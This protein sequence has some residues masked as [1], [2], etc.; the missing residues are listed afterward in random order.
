M[1]LGILLC[2]SPPAQS[3]QATFGQLISEAR[4]SNRTDA[5]VLFQAWRSLQ[6]QNSRRVSRISL[7]ETLD[8]RFDGPA[9]TWS[10]TVDMNVSGSTSSSR[11]QNDITGFRSDGRS[12]PRNDWNTL[13][14]QWQSLLGEPFASLIEDPALPLQLFENMSP[15]GNA[16]EERINGAMHW[17]IEMIPERGSAPYQRVTLWVHQEVGYLSRS[18]AVLSDRRSSIEVVTDYKRVNGID[19]PFQRQFEGKVQS[20]RRTR[21]TTLFFNIKGDYSG[22]RFR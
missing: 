9:G 8:S 7:S 12:V 3:Q 11:W 13:A 18:R 21:I 6:R 2:M 15:S 10:S 14:V 5:R 17:R 1:A 4:S 22:Y 20:R 16:K 19:V